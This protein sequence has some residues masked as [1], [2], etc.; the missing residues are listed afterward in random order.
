M[1]AGAPSLVE[2]R[3][4]ANRTIADFWGQPTTLFDEIRRAVP[5]PPPRILSG[6][7]AHALCAYLFP[8]NKLI[9]END[10]M[11]AQTLP[12]L[13]MPNRGNFI[14]RFPDKI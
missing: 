5:W 12:Q 14:V 1:P 13:K 3:I 6:D 9:G 2:G 10:G 4:P 7:E 8:V 11:N